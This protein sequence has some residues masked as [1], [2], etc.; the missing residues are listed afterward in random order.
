MRRAKVDVAAWKAEDG[1][2]EPRN[3]GGLQKL[4]KARKWLLF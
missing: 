4:E 1:A 2:A 3:E